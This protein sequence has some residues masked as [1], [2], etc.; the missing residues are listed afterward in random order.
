MLTS[1][2]T[3]LTTAATDLILA[4]TVF[5]FAFF[6]TTNNDNKRI[7]ASLW[8]YLF[9]LAA[10]GALFGSMAH[11]LIMPKLINQLIWWLIFLCLD[12]SIVV[13]ALVALYD[14]SNSIKGVFILVFLAI[15]SYLLLITF[16]SFL[17]FI[18]YQLAVMLSALIAYG[19][20]TYSH[21]LKGA[22]YLFFGL[23]F[24]IIG[25][26]LQAALN[27]QFTIIWT[28]NHNS[29]YHILSIIGMSLIFIGIRKDLST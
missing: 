29:I 19:Y 9:T 25:A 15:V 6:I 17:M 7:R 13:L 20:L 24:M 4:L 8:R 5:I 3:G 2:E 16:D 1:V 23:G 12:I 10:L 21:R 27:I 26:V 28:F 22:G 11:G 18:I 14:C